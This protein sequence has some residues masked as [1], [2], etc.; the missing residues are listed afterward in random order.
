MSFSSSLFYDPILLA[1]RVVLFIPKYVDQNYPSKDTHSPLKNQLRQDDIE[2][3][4]WAG[5][6]L[7]ELNNVGIERDD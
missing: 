3:F 4:L 2:G 1:W 6:L 5:T 7:T